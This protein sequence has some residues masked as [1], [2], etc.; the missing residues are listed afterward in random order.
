VAAL[1]ES[2]LRSR[3]EGVSYALRLDEA[4]TP[5]F[6]A[7]PELARSAGDA[8]RPEH[9]VD[10]A[11]LRAKRVY[12]AAATTRLTSPM[13]TRELKWLL[14]EIWPRKTPTGLNRATCDAAR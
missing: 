14:D 13:T 2:D 12:P 9:C 1:V 5:S 4:R 8:C 10:Q 6:R 7:R 3:S 11:S